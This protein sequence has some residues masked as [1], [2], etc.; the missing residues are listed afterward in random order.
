LLSVLNYFVL[1]AIHGKV[2]KQS[3]TC[4]LY[5]IKCGVD[6]VKNSW[7][8]DLDRSTSAAG[9]KHALHKCASASH[10]GKSTSYSVVPTYI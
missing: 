7:I 3:V 10:L 9:L 1:R 8:S 2:K 4:G 5:R 6:H